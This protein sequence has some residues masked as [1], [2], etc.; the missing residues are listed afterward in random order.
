MS[1]TQYSY[2]SGTR[3]IVKI[4]TGDGD[5]DLRFFCCKYMCLDFQMSFDFSEEF[6]WRIFTMEEGITNL[7]SQLMEV[8]R[9]ITNPC[10]CLCTKPFFTWEQTQ[11]LDGVFRLG[12]DFQAIKHLIIKMWN[13]EMETESL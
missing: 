4:Y 8:D 2:K 6:G 7:N 10:C 3:E 1:N 9:F 11:I 12:L 5:W 13:V